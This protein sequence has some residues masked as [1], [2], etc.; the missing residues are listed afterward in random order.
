MP[1]MSRLISTLILLPL[2]ACGA[3]KHGGGDDDD[4][5]GSDGAD[6]GPVPEGKQRLT[7]TV[8]G[9]GAVTS[10]PA[11]IDCPDACTA[12]FDEGTEVVLTPVAQSTTA[13]AAWSG[14]CGAFDAS[15]AVTMDD[16][17][18]VDATF[19]LHGSKRW[20]AQVS[21]EGQDFIEHDVVL[22]PDGNP[23]IAGTVDNDDDED[24]TPDG[25][26][27]Y[28]A[29]YDKLTGDLLWE[30][31]VD[32]TS[33]EYYGGLAVD[34]GGDVYAA[35]TILGFDPITIDG[36]SYTP[37]LFGNMIVMRLARDTGDF[38]WVKQWGGGAQDRPHALVVQGSNL[39]VAGEISSSD[40][41]FDGIVVAGSTGDAV[42]VKARTDNGN[43]TRVK[44]IDGNLELNAIAASASKLAVAGYFSGTPTIDAGCN[45]SSSG[46]NSADGFMLQLTPADLDCE[47]S[48][49]FGDSATDMSCAAK[50]VAAYPGGGWV[51]T[52]D[53]KGNVLFAASGSSLPSRG[54]FDAFAVRYAANGTHV[55]SFRYGDTGFDLGT[56]VATTEDGSVILAGTFAADITFGGF[57]LSGANDVYLTRMSPGDAPSHEWAVALG[58]DSTDS[59]DS[60]AVTAEGYPYV[61]AYF[62]GMTTVDGQTMTALDYDAWLGA[63][64]R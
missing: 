31:L 32:T 61:L 22:D 53:F 6:A 26:D 2:L 27:M 14:D 8:T 20:V 25:S 5:D 47:W 55:W 41:D 11:G 3:V 46:S 39:Y 1:T 10:D 40:A 15:C 50:G 57:D 44:L 54:S 23:I 62:N 4:D 42:I 7:V 64:I 43:A 56:A 35:M 34:A 58:G 33:G 21:F 28:V 12:D 59:P 52:G 30:R 17:R 19:G 24:G 37:D 49:D 16:A 45:I 13:L 60:L 9:D 29:K 48:Q 36:D 18:S 63:M 38:V 51:V